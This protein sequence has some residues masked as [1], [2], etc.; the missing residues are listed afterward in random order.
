MR[1]I[2]ITHSGMLIISMIFPPNVPLKPMSCSC[3]LCRW[4]VAYFLLRRQEKQTLPRRRIVWNIIVCF[5][6][7]FH[8]FCA[9]RL[10]KRIKC[11]VCGKWCTLLIMRDTFVGNFLIN[12]WEE[13]RGATI[14]SV[15]RAEWERTKKR[16]A[17][18]LF[19]CLQTEKE[20][21]PAVNHQISLT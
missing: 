14:S 13:G 17:S 21:N 1:R 11:F 18:G 3:V 5:S 8:V 6:A 19:M 12:E 4:Q 2:I 7:R 16:A 20:N 10:F 9:I 15:A